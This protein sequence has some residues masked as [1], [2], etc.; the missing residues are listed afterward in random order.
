M[1]FIIHETRDTLCDT[2]DHLIIKS[3]PMVKFRFAFQ[4][5]I[6]ISLFCNGRDKQ[7]RYSWILKDSIITIL[8]H[9]DKEGFVTLLFLSTEREK[10]KYN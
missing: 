10:T 1:T 8:E 3:V 2:H 4:D 5:F 7:I 9:R 6:T